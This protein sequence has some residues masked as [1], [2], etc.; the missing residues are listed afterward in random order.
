M[1]FRKI[2]FSIVVIQFL[3]AEDI[4]DSCITDSINRNF[5][6]FQYTY[7]QFIDGPHVR[8]HFTTEA[9]D[10]FFFNNTW[11]THQSNLVYATT[12]LDQVEYSYSVYEDE[13]WQM[14]P[15][16]CDESITDINNSYHCVND[17]RPFGMYPSNGQKAVGQRAHCI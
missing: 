9:V 12:V 11:F 13:G 4:V 10:S 3:Y 1:I 15:P 17:S 5:D 16:D 6:R 8:V 2:I 7:P 14:P